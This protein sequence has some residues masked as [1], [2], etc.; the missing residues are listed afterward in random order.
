MPEYWPAAAGNPFGIAEAGPEPSTTAPSARPAAAYFRL[1]IKFL[2]LNEIL[3]RDCDRKVASTSCRRSESCEESVI[4]Y[5]KRSGSRSPTSGQHEAGD[6][7]VD[8][9]QRRH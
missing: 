4:F 7:G 2:L 8:A 1:V 9:D 6:V 3:Q 5:G